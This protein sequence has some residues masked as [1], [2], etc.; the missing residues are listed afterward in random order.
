MKLTDHFNDKQRSSD[1]KVYLVGGAVRDRLLGLPVSE[2]DWVVVGASSSRMKSLGFQS[3]G[4]DFP[5]FL[6]PKTKEEY[7]LARQEKKVAPGYHGFE[8]NS[9]SSVTLEEDLKRRDLTINAIAEDENQH[10]IDPY[11]G[12]QDLQNRILRHVSSAFRDDPVRVL[13]VARFLAR[14]SSLGFCIDEKTLSLMRDVVTAGEMDTLVPERIFAE[15]KKALATKAPH[16]FIEALNSCEATARVF[17]AFSALTDDKQELSLIALQNAVSL[18]DDLAIRFAALCHQLSEPALTQLCETIRCPKLYR[19]NARSAI[20][21]LDT[22]IKFDG[23]DAATLQLLKALDAF[24]RPQQLA[25]FLTVM[26]AV[27]TNKPGNDQK[28]HFLQTALTQC[29]AIDTAQLIAAGYKGK[30]LGEE[31]H[32]QRLNTIRQL[33]F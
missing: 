24:R 21:L 27:T 11:G 20:R 10:L 17:P 16:K 32:Q 3:V 9:D 14:F 5:V 30:Q 7:A 15:L 6:H 2:R 19:D 1:I 29:Q 4:K 22:Y 13:R 28:S 33:F 25:S 23:S 31:L 26:R 8:F 18:T 12:A